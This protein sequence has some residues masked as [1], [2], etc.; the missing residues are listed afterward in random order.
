MNG[1]GTFPERLTDLMT[2]KN[3]NTVT[4]GKEIGVSDETVRRWKNGQRSILLSQFLKIADYFNCSL[5]YL[6][7]RTDVYLDYTVKNLPLFYD[8]LRKIMQETG[9][10]RYALVKSL[11]IYDS[12][13]TNWK[14]GKSPNLVT[15][16]TLADFFN[17][18]IDYLVGRD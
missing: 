4:L 11:P 2:E 3:L 8:N 10:S 17:I 13:F 1:N 6:A 16:V 7:G 12:Y 18:S 15:L 9:V 14:Q 5:D